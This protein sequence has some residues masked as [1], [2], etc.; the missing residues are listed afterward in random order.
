MVDNY[1]QRN[2]KL[3]LAFLGC[4]TTVHTSTRAIPYLLVYC[5]EVIM[6][7][8]VDIPSLR[9][10]QEAE[11]GNVEWI[12][13]RYEKL[14]LIDGKRI[15]IVCHGQPYQ[16]KMARAFNKKVRSRQFK[17]GQLVLK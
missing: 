10:I 8:E 2:E 14:A 16:N 13:S 17:P 9:M 11:L 15:N 3:P 5:T 12:Q 6:P 1:K 4:R 7:A